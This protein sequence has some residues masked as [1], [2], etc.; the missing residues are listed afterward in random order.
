[1]MSYA[2]RTL[3]AATLGALV[4]ARAGGPAEAAIAAGARAAP[5]GT[6]CTVAPV[7]TGAKAEWTVSQKTFP[8]LLATGR[9]EVRSAYRMTL[10][11]STFTVYVLQ[12]RRDLRFVYECTADD[13][14]RPAVPCSQVEIAPPVPR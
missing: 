3:L 13:T 10:C 12:D 2:M 11:G 5:N 4:A 8:S 1:M 9:F 14:Y 6:A 7:D